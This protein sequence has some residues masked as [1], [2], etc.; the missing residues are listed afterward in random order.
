[1]IAAEGLPVQ[2]AV[3]VLGVSDSGYDEWLSR[4]PSARAIRHVWLSEQIA[5]VPAA[6]RGAYGARRVHAETGPRARPGRRARHDRA[7]HAPSPAQGPTRQPPAAAEAPD[8]T[9]ADRVD[10]AFTRTGRDQLWVTDITEHPTREGKVYC[11]V[12]LDVYSR[13][14]VG[15]SIDSTQTAALVTSA[16]DIA[17]RNRTPPPGVVIHSDHGVQFTPWT[18]T[19]RAHASGLIPSMGS[20]GDCYDNAVIESFWG[21][22]QTELLNRRRWRARIELANAIFEYLEIF[23]NRQRRHSALGMLTPVE[24]E[25]RTPL[26]A[27]VA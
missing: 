7:A 12:V 13:R 4:P 24:Y 19:Q 18:F 22:M 16:L 15:W 8:P 14:V 2:T 9:A 17:I 27:P 20:I 23:H 11:A 6:S 1:V 5:A 10:R 21:R 3:R 25:I 26:T